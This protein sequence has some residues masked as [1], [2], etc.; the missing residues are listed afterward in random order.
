MAKV[1]LLKVWNQLYKNC[2][3]II[4]YTEITMSYCLGLLMLH[5]DGNENFHIVNL[6][7]HMLHIAMV[8]S[9]SY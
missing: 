7:S 8:D 5:H 3:E 2:H 4:G 9:Y 1:V 6:S